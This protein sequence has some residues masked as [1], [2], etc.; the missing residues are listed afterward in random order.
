MVHERVR[1][2]QLR[3]WMEK[4]FSKSVLWILI[5]LLSASFQPAELRFLPTKLKITVLNELGNPVEGAEVTVFA[6][7][8]DYRAETNAVLPTDKTDE[9]GQVLFKGLDPIPYYIHA[10]NSGQSNIG[11]GVLTSELKEGRINKV[12]TVIG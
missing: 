6:T 11:A 2:N 8:D 10:D 9:N 1:A 4:Y 12:N 3:I 5:F 7:K